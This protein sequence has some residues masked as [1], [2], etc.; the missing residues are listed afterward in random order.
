MTSTTTQ[1][2]YEPC[3]PWGSLKQAIEELHRLLEPISWSDLPKTN[4]DLLPRFLRNGWHDSLRILRNSRRGIG[5]TF[6]KIPR[7]VMQCTRIYK[8]CVTEE[9]L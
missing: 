3:D 7:W 4:E 8:A 1:S 2:R 9:C 6:R 5:I